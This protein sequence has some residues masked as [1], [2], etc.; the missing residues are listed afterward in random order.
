MDT[1]ATEWR[2]HR[3]LI[4][5]F[6][7]S[8]KALGPSSALSEDDLLLAFTCFSDGPQDI[9]SH[10]YAWV[11]APLAAHTIHPCSVTFVLCEAAWTTT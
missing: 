10:V 7:E 3:M 11:S 2:R 6:E 1:T 8:A 9:Q 5:A 4:A